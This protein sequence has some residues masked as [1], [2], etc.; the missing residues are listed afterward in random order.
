L[1]P[2]PPHVGAYDEPAPPGY[3]PVQDVVRA[4]RRAARQDARGAGVDVGDD[5]VIRDVP[6]PPGRRP[7]DAPAELRSD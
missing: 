3:V 4:R 7:S 5:D 1:R 6:P 2:S